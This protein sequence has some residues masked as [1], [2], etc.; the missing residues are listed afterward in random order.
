MGVI[1]GLALLFAYAMWALK[2]F[3]RGTTPGK[4]ALGIRVVKE[5]GCAATFGTMLMREWIGKIISGMVFSLG[6][7]WILIDQDRQGWH[8]KLVSTYVVRS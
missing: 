3:A 4:N 6:Y 2:L 1:A 8:D 7:I 5:D